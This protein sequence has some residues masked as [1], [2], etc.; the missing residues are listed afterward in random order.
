MTKNL[1]SICQNLHNVYRDTNSAY[2]RDPLHSELPTIYP[3]LLIVFDEVTIYYK[4]VAVFGDDGEIVDSS[5]LK[6]GEYDNANFFSEEHMHDSLKS[7]AEDLEAMIIVDDDDYLNAKISAHIS[8]YLHSCAD[9][10][11]QLYNYGE[12]LIN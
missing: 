6:V 4:L 2:F 1:Q 12:K 9:S 5:L 8:D 7:L 11:F 10:L 3:N